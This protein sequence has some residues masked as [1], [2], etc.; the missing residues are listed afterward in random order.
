M[1][2]NRYNAE[3]GAFQRELERRYLDWVDKQLKGE[4]QENT[5]LLQQA[6]IPQSQM[7]PVQP[8]MQSQQQITPQD[9]QMLQMGAGKFQD[10]IK[11]FKELYR[12]GGKKFLSMY[13]IN[14]DDKPRQP[15]R[16][17]VPE[18]FYYGGGKMERCVLAVKKKSGYKE[19]EKNKVNPWAV[20]NASIKSEEQSGSGK[21]FTKIM[22]I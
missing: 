11:K 8:L 18:D 5:M 13:G 1:E 22:K 9:K 2:A 20:C 19:G 17:T 14:V 15:T 10:I 16:Y 6:Q 3:Y 4:P 7:E 21:D 12:E